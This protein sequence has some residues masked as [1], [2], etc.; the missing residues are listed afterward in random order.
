MPADPLRLRILDAIVTLFNSVVA[1]S[2][3]H[4]TITNAALTSRIPFEEAP[5]NF[6]IID[7]MGGSAQLIYHPT[8]EV[9]P[10]MSII[11]RGSVKGIDIDGMEKLLADCKN[12]LAT[13]NTL[14]SL[15]IDVTPVLE[16]TD[17]GSLENSS[18][19]MILNARLVHVHGSA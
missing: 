5:G 17:E 2:T 16:S 4:T 18:F 19:E 9:Q 15:V 6:P 7:V 12:V 3:Y 8:G 1:G 13:N 14:G 10:E 11:V